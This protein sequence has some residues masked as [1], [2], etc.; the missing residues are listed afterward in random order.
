MAAAE[1][2]RRLKPSKS[3]PGCRV[4]DYARAVLDGNIP[5]A[6]WIKAAARRH[7]ADL[8]AGHERGLW[9]DDA[10]ARRAFAFIE[11]FLVHSKGRWN[12]QPFTLAPWQ[13]FIVGCL[14]GWRRADGT[15]R[16]RIAF[17][18]L[19]RKNGKT[20]L[21]AAI[22]LYLFVADGEAGAEI[23][24]VATKRDQA[25]LVFNDARA[26][27]GRSPDLADVVTRYVHSLEIP[28]LRA[29]F[30]PL[31]ADADTLDGLNPFFV[32][33]DEIHAWKS[34]DPW[35]VM[36]TG[37]GAREQPMLLAIT[38]AGDFSDSIYN[39]LR[40]DAEQILD[41]VATDDAVFAF[42]ATVEDPAKW[43]EPAEWARANPN[44][45]VSLDEKEL[46]ET[47]ERA[48]R[49]PSEQ[50]KVKRLRLGIRTTALE[51]WLRLDLWDS[52]S[53]EWDPAE[54]AGRPC[55]GGLDLASTQDFAAFVLVFP[56]GMDKGEPVYRVLPHFWLPADAD[57]YH[58]T[59]LRRRIVPWADAGLVELTPG[60]SIDLGRIEAT[61]LDLATRFEIGSVAYDP[62]NCEGTAGRLADL[63]GLNMLRFPQN[64]GQFNE[65][66]RAVERAV[67]GGRLLHRANPVLRWMASNCVALTN[68][69]GHTMPSRK[70]SRDKIDGVVALTMAIGAHIRA[71]DTGA[72]SVYDTRGF[73]D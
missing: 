29:K 46:A 28:E 6:K 72:S 36:L 51:A 17:V 25:K 67:A 37:M 34:R 70:K 19:P 5:A 16:F 4:A 65:P 23:Y 15:R 2:L 12:K 18:D 42:I 58:A 68:G 53:A 54:L 3:A 31:G 13:A 60:N 26:M 56:W 21:A 55:Y 50:N 33:C 7:L 52:G 63:G 1:P 62:F 57:D 38:T 71:G 64:A 22:A 35:D 66:A 40:S 47:V 48:K 24:S 69:A 30:E 9:W 11:G 14:F 8:E 45:G 61:V 20:T 32:V 73:D 41:G 10:A 59:R 39:E 44:L 43:T 27:V 49:R